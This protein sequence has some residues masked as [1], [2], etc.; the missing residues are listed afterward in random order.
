MVKATILVPV[1]DNDGRPFEWEA[2][3][4]LQ[5]RLLQFGGYTDG[6]LVAGAWESEGR[7]YQ[8]ENRQFIIA[9]SSWRDVP[10]FLDLAEWVRVRFRQEAVYIE[11]AGIPEILAG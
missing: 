8:D 2:W 4:E 3:Q 10:R 9:L 1:K 5:Q 6:G 11:I 7:V